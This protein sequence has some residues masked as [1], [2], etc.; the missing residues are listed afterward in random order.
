MSHEINL[1]NINQ[2][3]TKAGTNPG[4]RTQMFFTHE[5]RR[6]SDPYVPMGVGVLKNSSRVVNN[7][8]AIEYHTP[9]AQYHWYGVLMVDPLTGSSWARAGTQKVLTNRGMK[10]RGAPM[11]G[12]RWVDRAFEH[13]KEALLASVEKVANQ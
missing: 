11:R 4:G 5:L 12:P 13:N 10:Y 1:P 2:V 7:H 9:Y 3:I 6:L 8:T